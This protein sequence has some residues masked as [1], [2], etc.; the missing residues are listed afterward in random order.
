[1]NTTA[2]EIEL[3]Q[4][5]LNLTEQFDIRM[6]L[7]MTITG[8]ELRKPVLDLTEQFYIRKNMTAEGE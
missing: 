1:M 6:N 5:V 7:F 2:M 4:P 8:I 3:R